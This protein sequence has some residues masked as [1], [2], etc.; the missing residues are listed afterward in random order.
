MASDISPSDCGEQEP[1]DT[2]LTSFFACLQC[3]FHVQRT[4]IRNIEIEDLI[5]NCSP[6]SVLPA[7]LVF[8]DVR[9]GKWQ[10]SFGL[11]TPHLLPS[12]HG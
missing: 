10:M 11:E 12:P 9:R 8:A 3:V 1:T 6:L 5:R 4:S 7:L 2:P